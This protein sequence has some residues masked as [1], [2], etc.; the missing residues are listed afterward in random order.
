LEHSDEETDDFGPCV[1]NPCR[2]LEYP[3]GDEQPVGADDWP[4]VANGSKVGGWA[5]WWQSSPFGLERPSCGAD[6]RLLLAL[7]THE[8]PEKE[9]CSCE[10]AG[11]AVVGW[12]FGRE[13]ALNVF[14]CTTDVQHPIKLH[15]D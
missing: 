14:A 12:E 8:E 4:P 15:I 6:R 1:L 5:F 11:R 10:V 7:Y 9:L 2:I 3:M 13:G